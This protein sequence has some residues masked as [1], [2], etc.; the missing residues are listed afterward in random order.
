VILL[1]VTLPGMSGWELLAIIKSYTR[2]A[3]IPVDSGNQKLTH[4]GHQE[5][6][7]PRSI[8]SVRPS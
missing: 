3:R 5:L 1:D 6:T 7:H 4:P 8:G 2:L